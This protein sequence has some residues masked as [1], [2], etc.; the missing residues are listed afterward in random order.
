[1]IKKT[2][3]LFVILGILLS[4]LSLINVA[5]AQSATGTLSFSPTSVAFADGET[6]TLAVVYTGTEITAAEVHISVG[7]GLTITNFSE[8]D[9]L[10]FIIDSPENGEVHV[11]KLSAGNI[12]SGSTLFTMDVQASGCTAGGEISF[13]AGEVLVPDV[14]MS[15]NS[16]TYTCDG[17]APPQ[18]TTGG[19]GGGGGG[20]VPTSLPKTAI[21]SEEFDRLLVASFILSSGLGIA[22]YM[23][24]NRVD[25]SPDFELLIKKPTTY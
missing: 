19:S 11:G 21:I 4:N 15:F 10:I 17:T 6:K 13:N 22:Y 2:T 20:G 18:P 24:M 14:Q 5:N 9:G 23:K 7:A 3:K 8:G 25:G 16:A 1:M 12:T